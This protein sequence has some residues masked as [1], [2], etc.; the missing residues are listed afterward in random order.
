[1]RIS[2]EGIE[3]SFGERR[4]LSDL[5]ADFGEIRSV[6]LIGP[7]GG[8]KSTLLRI[9]AGLETPDAGHVLLDDQPI[10]FS[11]EAALRVHRRQLGVVFQDRK[12][13]V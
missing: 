9:I 1:M 5:A 10:D 2:I 4:V 8:G 11:S 6:A 7:S 3:K 12:S 13:V